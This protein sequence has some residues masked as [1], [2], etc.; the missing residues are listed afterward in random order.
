M[1]CLQSEIGIFG[2]LLVT[3]GIVGAILG[4]FL[5]KLFEFVAIDNFFLRL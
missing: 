3:V 5:R 2:F 1:F 4:N